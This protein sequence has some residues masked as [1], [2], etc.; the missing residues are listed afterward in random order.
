[1]RAVVGALVLVGLIAAPPA[2]A[3]PVP[4]EPGDVVEIRIRSTDLFFHLRGPDGETLYGV[5]GRRHLLMTVEQGQAS[6]SYGVAASVS[7]RRV[8]AEVGR[9]GSVDVRFDPEGASRFRPARGGCKGGTD[10]Q[11]GVV[12]GAIRFEGDTGFAP[13]SATSARASVQRTDITC[14]QE[15]GNPGPQPGGRHVTQLIAFGDFDDRGFPHSGFAAVHGRGEAHSRF[16]AFASSR[17]GKVTID[18]GLELRADN[19]TFEFDLRARRA[20]VTPPAPFSGTAT[21][22]RS[23]DAASWTGDLAATFP[24]LPPTPLTGPDF[25]ADLG[26]STIHVLARR[27]GAAA[28]QLARYAGK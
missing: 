22:A 27:M 8:R 7:D 1:M 16:F 3:K 24:G 11:P 13:L 28:R 21:F 19:S 14:Q 17:E 23:D 4:V 25:E 15:V 9:F 12:E 2:A 5:A 6:I 26:R 18:H 10:I 20:T